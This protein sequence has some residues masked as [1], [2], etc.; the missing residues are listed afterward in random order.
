MLLLVAT[1]GGSEVRLPAA[2]EI[3][4]PQ[5]QFW[6]PTGFDLLVNRAKQMTTNK[7]EFH[8]G[9]YERKQFGWY[10]ASR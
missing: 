10:H 1:N 3:S 4:F 9:D 8:R 7:K 5:L 2:D 6:L